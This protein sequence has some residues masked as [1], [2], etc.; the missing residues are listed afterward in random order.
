M[1]GPGE[2]MG[3][4]FGIIVISMVPWLLLGLAIPY[5]VLRMRERG[6]SPDPYIG[7][8]TTHHFFM[9]TG[10]FFMLTGFTLLAVRLMELD[11]RPGFRGGPFGGAGDGFIDHPMVRVAFAFLIVGG[12]FTLLHGLLLLG[13]NDGRMRSVRRAFTG[14]RF[15]VSG[16]VVLITLTLIL[17]TLLQPFIPDRW[18]VIKP[19]LGVLIVWV[20]SWF[21]HM[22]FLLIGTP[23][24]APAT[25]YGEPER[26]RYDQD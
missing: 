10:I 16:I 19:F 18:S 22:I 6:G 5:A 17:S 8:K 3:F 25:D 26:D 9:T 14:L 15:V 2:L 13:T 24:P 4:S 1:F 12:I 21:L 11:N 20:P 23:R 7:V